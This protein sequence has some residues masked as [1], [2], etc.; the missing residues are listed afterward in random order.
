MG[1]VV[2]LAFGGAVIRLWVTDGPEIP[3]VFI[4]FWLVGFF[5]FPMLHWNGFY[6][7][8]YEAILA[9]ILL[10]IEIYKG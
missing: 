9:S 1:L 2:L 10:I 3:I 8:A 5:V 4:G 6:F 7:L